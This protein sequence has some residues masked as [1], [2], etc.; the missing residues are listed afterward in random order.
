VVQRSRRGLVVAVVVQALFGLVE[1]S[2]GP[3]EDS[4][5][6]VHLQAPAK[7]PCSQAGA[8]PA[9]NGIVTAGDLY[10]PSTYYAYVL[11]TDADTLLG[12]AGAQFGVAYAP[13]SEAGV[14]VFGWTSCASLQFPEETWPENGSG[15]RITWS[16]ET[17]CQ[18]SEPGG[19]GTGVVVTVGFFYCAAY[20]ADTLR[21]TVWPNDS[22]ATVAACDAKEETVESPTVQHSPSHLGFA[23]FSSGGTVPGHNPCG[24]GGGN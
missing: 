10:P 22:A 4:K 1:A 2:A 5:L 3:N 16:P 12:V 8:A 17:Q 24:Q 19:P 20:S 7:T 13:S 23:V 18:R 9:C 14:D 11:V 15:N 6:V 21:V